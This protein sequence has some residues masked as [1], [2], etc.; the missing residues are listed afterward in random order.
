M[1]NEVTMSEALIVTLV[2][3]FVVFV[4]LVMI[5]LLIG[6]LKNMGKESG[7]KAPEPPKKEELKPDL[8]ESENTEEVE[9]QDELIAV[10]SAAI[11][12]SLGLNIPDINI[13]S[14]RRTNQSTT[15]WREMSKQ[16]HLYGKL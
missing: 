7:K 11:A 4:V 8:L 12:A 9:D 6:L 2:S 15:V 5:S 10:I 14:I 3:M 16:E 1:G 13:T